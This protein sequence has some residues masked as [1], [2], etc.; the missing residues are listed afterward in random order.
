MSKNTSLT[1][2]YYIGLGYVM[3][4]LI[5]VEWQIG[6]AGNMSPSHICLSTQKYESIKTHQSKWPGRP[7][8]QQHWF[9]TRFQHSVSLVSSQNCLNQCWWTARMFRGIFL[10]AL[11]PNKQ[12]WIVIAAAKTYAL[13]LRVSVWERPAVNCHLKQKTRQDL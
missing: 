9:N 2:S 7:S 1:D 13:G 10:L 11:E 5:K 3:N 12:F 8:F 4:H 6:K